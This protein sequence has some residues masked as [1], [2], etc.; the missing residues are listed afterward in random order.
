VLELRR[1]RRGDLMRGRDHLLSLIAAAA[2]IAAVMPLGARVWWGFEL[3]SHFRVQYVVLDVLLLVAFAWRRRW[4]WAGALAACAAWSALVVAPYLPFGP[5]AAAAPSAAAVGATI[6]LLS[7]NVFFHNH[8]TGKLL[9]IV[10]EES[11]DIVLLV[12]YTPEWSAKV[13][14]LRRA[15]PHRL[16]G[17]GTGA[18]GIALF[19]RFPVDSIEPFALGTT[20][21]IEAHVRTPSGPLTL[22][23]VHLRSPSAPRRA[24]SRNRQL[25]LLAARLAT[26][27]GSVAVM[28]DF[29]VTPYSPYYTDFLERTGLTDTRRGRTLSPSWP[30]YF[31]VIGIPIDHCIVSRDLHVVAHRGL[32]GFGSDHYP[33]LAELALPALPL[34]ITEN[35]SKP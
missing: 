30:A 1:E 4:L 32:G 34:G 18:Y 22:F 11:P 27:K 3:A 9:Q 35:T 25:E 16:E 29:N 20:T 24:A 21:A 13:D 14:E 15:Y 26:V 8:A 12:E 23:G 33:I 5:S 28:G 6:K 10:R 2:V 31:P 7:A 19:S 17:P